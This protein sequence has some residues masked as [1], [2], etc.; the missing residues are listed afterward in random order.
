MA[1]HLHLA[2][3][4]GI[5]QRP[6]PDAPIRV[7]LADDHAG[8]RRNLRL[9]LDREEGLEVIAEAADLST[10][11]RHVTGHQP[12]VLVLDLQMPNGSS[13]EVIRRLHTQV[14]QT[15]I[16]VLTMETSPAFA[17]QALEAGAIG[18]VLKDQADTELPAAVRRAARGDEFVSPHVAAGLAALQDMVTVDGLSARETEVLRLI[19][20]GHTS[21]EI[22]DMLH[23]SR[24]T[25]ETHRA[26][27]HRKLGLQTR[28]Q[29]VRYALG[30]HLIGA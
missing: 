23:L 1:S 27:I 5:A 28:A 26:R 2:P 8:V 11:L 17:Q 15:Q 13:L 10:V 16:V 29:L 20:L 21:A 12:H 25:V 24:R 22:A 3:A 30:R 9:L 18:F 7:I 14:P 6:W 19:A 4:E